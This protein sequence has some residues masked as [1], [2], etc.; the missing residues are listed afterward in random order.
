MRAGDLTTPALLADASVLDHNVA[1]M[2]VARPGST[3]RPHVKAFK[4]TALQAAMQLSLHRSLNETTPLSSTNS[5][6]QPECPRSRFDAYRG[7][8]SMRCAFVASA[9]C[10]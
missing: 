8:L 3:L 10:C 2:S 9:S 7:C 5:S 1:A 4:C 6:L